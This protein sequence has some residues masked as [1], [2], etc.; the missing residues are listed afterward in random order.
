MASLITRYTELAAQ[1]ALDE[2]TDT[3]TEIWCVAELT[4]GILANSFMPNGEQY[5]VVGV[6]P[7]CHVERGRINQDL[8]WVGGSVSIIIS[9]SNLFELKCRVCTAAR[10][11]PVLT[12]E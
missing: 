4:N 1:A 12:I 2:G 5:R 8:Q 9:V 6:K 7:V 3:E 10:W 11:P